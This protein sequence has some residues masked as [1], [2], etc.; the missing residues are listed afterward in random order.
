MRSGVYLN[1]VKGACEL[2]TGVKN[3]KIGVGQISGDAL[4]YPDGDPSVIQSSSEIMQS[5]SGNEGKLLA[6]ISELRRRVF[7]KLVSSVVVHVGP[8]SVL[9]YQT[10]NDF[11]RITNM[12]V[13][14]LNLKSG[15]VECFHDRD[16]TGVSLG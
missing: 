2:L 6:G 9:L 3:G 11:L 5:I 10:P 15:I 1:T 8:R 4:N 13:G 14:P 12:F 16:F 7:D